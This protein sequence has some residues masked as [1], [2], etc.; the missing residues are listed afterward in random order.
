MPLVNLSGS[1]YTIFIVD[2]PVE[3]ISSD[4]YGMRYVDVYVYSYYQNP[5]EVFLYATGVPD[6][7]S[8]YFSNDSVIPN[9]STK[10]FLDLNGVNA[11]N[12]TIEVCGTNGVYTD[13]DSFVLNV[14]EYKT[15]E[16]MQLLSSEVFVAMLILGTIGMYI[17]SV[18]PEIGYSISALS[19]VITAIKY[20]NLMAIMIVLMAMLIVY[21]IRKLLFG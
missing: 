15:P 17:S 6:N 13:C 10:L 7:V 4:P 14:E 16:I 21:A 1:N 5:N 9:S 2:I 12:Y 3:N 20:P 19:L 8:Y 11:G 18:A